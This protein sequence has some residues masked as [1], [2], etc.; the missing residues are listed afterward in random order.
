MNVIL[1]I[2]GGGSHTR[3]LA[4]GWSGRILGAGIGGASNHLLVD[5]K[6]VRASL[7]EA[8]NAAL[9]QATISVSDVDCI[10]AGLAGVDYDGSG[11]DEMECIFRDFGFAK[12]AVSG[13]M[14]TAHAGALAGQPGVL[15]LAGTGSCVLGIGEDGTRIK[16]GGWGPV[17]GDEGSAYR[18]GQAALRASARD[19]D[20]RGPKTGLTAAIEKELGIR[21]FKESLGAVYLEKMQPTEIARLSKTAYKAAQDGDEVALSIFK[22]AGMELA[23]CVAAAIRRLG[24]SGGD[25]RVS[26]QGSVITKCEFM[27]E[28]FYTCLADGFPG[29]AVIAPR[30]PPVIGA[31]LIGRTTLNLLNDENLFST[32]KGSLKADAIS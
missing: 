9:A 20:G 30:F 4:L 7:D 2:D 27:R 24:F 5:I 12:M 17:F 23:E 6:I 14:V 26:Y 8:I 19:F 21:G 13:D 10:S 28:S 29:V 22:T 11:A 1:A 15:A 16:V 3:C 32:I 25:A 18:I 31:Y